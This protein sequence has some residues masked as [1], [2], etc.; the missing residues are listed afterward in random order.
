MALDGRQ[1]NTADNACDEGPSPSKRQKL[2][3]TVG[4]T[5]LEQLKFVIS[6]SAIRI[7]SNIQKAYLHETNGLKGE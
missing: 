7:E 2:Q 6:A 4:P 5:S 3:H 1:T